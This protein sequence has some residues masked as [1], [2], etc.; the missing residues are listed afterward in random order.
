MYSLVVLLS[1]LASASFVLAFVRGS[2]RH[3]PLLGVW[4]TLL[5]YTHTWGLFLAASMAV[6]G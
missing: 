6:R 5:L 4:L 3:V 2:R 1:I